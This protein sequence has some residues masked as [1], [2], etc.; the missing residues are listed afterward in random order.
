M[1]SETEK[2]KQEILEKECGCN[3]HKIKNSITEV[4][5][6][7]ENLFGKEAFTKPD[8][9]VIGCEPLCQKCGKK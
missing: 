7:M 5:T 3:C 4:F 8:I 6:G 1:T 2:A 9:S